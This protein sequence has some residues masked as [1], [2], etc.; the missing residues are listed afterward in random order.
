MNIANSTATAV[1][2]ITYNGTALTLVGAHNDAGNTR[3]VEQWYLLNPASGTNLPIIVSVNI[4]TAATVG[5]A[6][7]ATVFTGVDQTVPL[8]S[9]VSGNGAA[10][11]HSELDVPSV[12]NGMVFDTL[13]VGMGAIAVP[14]PQVTQWNVTSGGTTPN[15]SQD[16]ASSAS[17]RTGAPSVPVSEKF[18]RNSQPH[19]GCARRRRV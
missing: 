14:G 1:S 5:V 17:S 10:A 19:I 13:A 7:G 2:G 16:I 8:G 4:P 6:A 12:V 9:F 15:A 18:R 11:A 3:R